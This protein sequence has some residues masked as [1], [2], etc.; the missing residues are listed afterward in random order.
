MLQGKKNN[1]RFAAMPAMIASI[2]SPASEYH[3]AAESRVHG[4][5]GMTLSA[6]ARETQQPSR[7]QRLS[8]AKNS[9]GNGF[10]LVVMV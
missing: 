4:R 7:R 1:D 5:M 8:S 3:S 10:Q 9:S 2:A 6:F